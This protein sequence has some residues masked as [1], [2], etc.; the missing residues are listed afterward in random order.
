MTEITGTQY[1]CIC[2]SNTYR[3]FIL[4]WKRATHKSERLKGMTLRTLVGPSSIG[5]P[6]HHLIPLSVNEAS[7]SLEQYFSLLHTRGP[8][9]K[10]LPSSVQGVGLWLNLGCFKSLTWK[11]EFWTWCHSKMQW[12][13]SYANT[14]LM[15]LSFYSHPW[16]FLGPYSFWDLTF[17]FWISELPC[18]LLI[19]LCLNLVSQNQLLLLTNIDSWPMKAHK[20]NKILYSRRKTKCFCGVVITNKLE[21]THKMCL[22]SQVEKGNR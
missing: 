8:S 2:I 3:N 12:F 22:K 10:V 7:T 18:I 6:A 14:P 17:P 9:I 5:F 1:I 15:S 4:V 20:N 13:S 19:N 11:Y 16:M 21:L